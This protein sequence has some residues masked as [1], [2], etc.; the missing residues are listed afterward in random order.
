M[1]DNRDNPLIKS[2]NFSS[3]FQLKYMSSKLYFMNVKQNGM[4]ITEIFMRSA[5]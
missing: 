2:K 3:D 5:Q 4:K 1:L